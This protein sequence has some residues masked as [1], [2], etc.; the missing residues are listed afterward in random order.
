VTT[1]P[2]AITA[3]ERVALARAR[4][5]ALRGRGRVSPNPAVGAVVLRDGATVAEGWHE[6]PGMPHAEAMA[7]AAAGDAAR[8]ATVVCTL[9][10]CSHHGRTP[11]C[12]HA[13]V[14]AGV[15][16]VVVGLADPLE[17][18]R[19]GGVEVLRAAGIDVAIA[20]DPERGDCAALVAPFLTWALT[21]RPEV[22]LKLATSLDGR[23]ATATGESRWISGAAARAL[24]HRWRADADAVVVGL[25][26]AL[27]DDPRLTARGVEG[28]VRQPARVVF[29]SSARLPLDAALV[30]D[31]AAAP[32]IVLASEEAPADRVRALRAAGVEVELLP[33][34]ARE[35]VGGGLRALGAR[36]IQSALVEGGAG[37]AAAMVE[38]GAVDRI[39]WFLAPM[40]IGGAGAPSALAGRGVP[41]LADA[42]R[43]AG[44]AVERVGDDVLV[45]GRLRPIPGP[46][47]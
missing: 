44:V 8:G 6:G 12:A 39:A 28:P 4:E 7:L 42:P 16:R 1:A 29:D 40:L 27:A 14:A 37:L 21:G 26:T 17:R 25:G 36:G 30:A 20:D 41:S 15:A 5:L 33:G 24:V 22:T 23:I 31:L 11:P 32:V 10:P 35:R 18:D 19:A 47:R 9:E 2:A 45:T 13:L 43:L 34:D 46:G 38:A 3:A